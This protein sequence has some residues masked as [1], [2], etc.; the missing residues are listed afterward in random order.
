M[1][2]GGFLRETGR[3]WRNR[4]RL[5]PR[6]L[7]AHLENVNATSGLLQGMKTSKKKK[8]EKR[9]QGGCKS[10]ELRKGNGS[11][12]NASNKPA[13]AATAAKGEAFG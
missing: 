2:G 1:L 5:A 3:R 7:T 10:L 4:G 13:R 9:S 12:E 11:F 8:K 6:G